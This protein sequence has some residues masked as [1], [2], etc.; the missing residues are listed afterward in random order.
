[1]AGRGPERHQRQ[2]R[3]RRVYAILA[4]AQAADAEI[5]EEVEALRDA[6][7]D[8]LRRAEEKADEL[9]GRLD[10]VVADAEIELPEPVVPEVEL[11]EK[12]PGSVLVSSAWTWV[13]QTHG[14]LKARKGSG[15][16]DDGGAE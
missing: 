14:S 3:Q 7:E 9:N 2:A 15:N 16:G 5:A 4:E 8:I 12:A 13:E 1:M 6:I 11:A 10:E